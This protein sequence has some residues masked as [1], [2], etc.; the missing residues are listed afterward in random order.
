MA[1]P[2]LDREGKQIGDLHALRRAQTTRSYPHGRELVS[3]RGI[4]TTSGDQ[5]QP[6]IG[7]ERAMGSAWQRHI[8]PEY[9]QPTCN[10]RP[11]HQQKVDKSQGKG[12]VALSGSLE[13]RDYTCTV[14]PPTTKVV[15]GV[16]EAGLCTS[17]ALQ[18]WAF[19]PAKPFVGAIRNVR[20]WLW[21]PCHRHC[22]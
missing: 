4:M 11:N 20:S 22:V 17:N 21:R 1:R 2:V 16:A 9:M 8:C 3:K 7:G 10:L 12:R 5:L 15:V 18:S 19:A 6:N 14:L 13:R